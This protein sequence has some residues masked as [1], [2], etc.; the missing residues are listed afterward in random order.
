MEEATYQMPYMVVLGPPP[1]PAPALTPNIYME[2]EQ[3]RVEEV[4]RPPRPSSA[5]HPTPPH[6]HHAPSTASLVRRQLPALSPIQIAFSETGQQFVN[7]NIQP[8]HRGAM[9]HPRGGGLEHPR[10]G[11][12]EHPRGG[13]LEHPR[14]GGLEHQH[15]GGGPPEKLRGG[16]LGTSTSNL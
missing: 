9:E 12:L 11:G 14:G 10:G 2:I 13:G 7:L 3:G 1:G 16:P 5:P 15:L 4:G 6:L 8:H